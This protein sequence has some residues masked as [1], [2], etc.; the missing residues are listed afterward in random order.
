MGGLNNDDFEKENFVCNLTME[1]ELQSV[2]K[3]W[4]LESFGIC[5]K[6]MNEEV[7]DNTKARCTLS[8]SGPVRRT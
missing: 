1:S 7:S 3:F 5:E 4:D 6:E 2:K 8:G